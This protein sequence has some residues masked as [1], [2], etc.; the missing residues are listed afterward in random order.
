M[1]EKKKILSM[2]EALYKMTHL[3]AKAFGLKDR[4]LIREGMKADI[5]IFN[6]VDIIDKAT[7]ESPHQYPEGINYVI[8]N[9]KLAIDQSEFK[10]IKSGEILRKNQIN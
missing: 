6:E 9:G 7:F 1:L 5:T 8:I 10:K 4:G 3:P 2:K